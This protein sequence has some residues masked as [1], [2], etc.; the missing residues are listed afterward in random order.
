MLLLRSR[1]PSHTLCREMMRQMHLRL[2]Q[3]SRLWLL[4]QHQRLSSQLKMTQSLSLM[5]SGMRCRRRR[6][7]RRGR[8]LLRR[9]HSNRRQMTPRYHKKRHHQPKMLRNP[10]MFS[11]ASQ[12]PSKSKALLSS[13]PRTKSSS[14]SKLLQSR[15]RSQS[16]SKKPLLPSL[17]I[18][19]NL[20]LRAK[21]AR[22]ARRLARTQ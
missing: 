5:T 10:K 7:V 14:K 13:H 20:R 15:L 11:Q 16:S 21:R 22:K 18:F 4:T 3:S 19:G 2:L 9:L 17:R 6:R 1:R 12:H 8:R